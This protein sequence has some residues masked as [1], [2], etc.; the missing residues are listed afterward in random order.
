MSKVTQQDGGSTRAGA[1]KV[2][3]MLRAY[4]ALGTDSS[5]RWAI[6]ANKTDVQLAN[7]DRCC[8]IELSAVMKCSTSCSPVQWPRSWCGQRTKFLLPAF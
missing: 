2:S 1:P 5:G 8:P 4:H 7:V 6:A 3:E